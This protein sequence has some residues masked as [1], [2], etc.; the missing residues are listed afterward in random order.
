MLDGGLGNDLLDGGAGDDVL[1][2]GPGQDI[3]IGGE[4]ADRHCSS[5]STERGD[6]IAA[7]MPAPATRSISATL[8][9]GAADP[10]AIDPFV[11]FAPPATTSWSASTRTAAGCYF[12][13]IAMAR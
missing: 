6:E 4:G 11:R 7:S 8:F 5:R 10:D 2:G 3:L 12:G 1:I 9:Q 13:F